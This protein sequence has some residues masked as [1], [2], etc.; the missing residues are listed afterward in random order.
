MTELELKENTFYVLTVKKEKGKKI[1][2]YNDMDSPIS[3][4]KEYLKD[5]KSPDDIELMAV[6]I[7]E[8]KFEIKSIPWSMIAVGLIKE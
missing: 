3:R 6:E 4:V 7:K 1:T 5:K 8:D 2:L